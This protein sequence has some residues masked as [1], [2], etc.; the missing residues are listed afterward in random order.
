MAAHIFIIVLVGS[1]QR[2]T[3]EASSVHLE[4]RRAAVSLI[5]RIR[6]PEGHYARSEKSASEVPSL[7][8]LFEQDWVRHPEAR[9]ELLFIRRDKSKQNFK[10]VKGAAG[11]GGATGGAPAHVAFPGGRTEESDEGALYTGEF[12]AFRTPFVAWFPGSYHF[13]FVGGSAMRQTWEEIGLDLA[14]KDF[15]CIGQLDDREITTSLGKRL[16]MILSPFGKSPH[17]IRVVRI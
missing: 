11:A 1:F 6:P 13:L 10:D 5:V 12:L 17:R 15:T 14:E 7:E 3:D 8:T 16:L 4:P 9:A 2:S